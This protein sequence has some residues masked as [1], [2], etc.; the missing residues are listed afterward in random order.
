MKQDKIWEYF[1]NQESESFEGSRGRLRF[2][3]KDIKAG[4]KVLNIGVGGAILE[5]MSYSKNID[6]HSLDPNKTTIENLRKLLGHEK[7][8]VGYS[9]EIPFN[10][11]CFDFVIMSEVLEHLSDQIIL[12]T[13]EE[14]RRVLKQDGKFI[15]TVPYNE[16]LNEQIVICPKCGEKF[17]RWGHIQSFDE[18]RMHQLLSSYFDNIKVFPKMFM[19]WNILNWKGKV[20]ASINYIFY[21]LGIKKSGLN[22]FFQ[23]IKK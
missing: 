19:S 3:I 8:K 9:Q 7:A 5:K 16:N 11:N 12:K 6:V 22:L 10:D 4:Q 1:Q 15:G 21:L 20:S 17:H 14:V 23:G 13:L 18:F 2:L